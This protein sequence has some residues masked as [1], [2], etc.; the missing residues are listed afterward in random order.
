MNRKKNAIVLG[1]GGFIGH[2]L[3]NR[4]KSEGF[5]VL[6]ADL[7]MPDF[8]KSNADEFL[9][10]DLRNL[11]FV[12]QVIFEAVDEVYQL[13]GDVGGAGYIFTGLNDAN[14]MH[15]SAQINLNV[16][17][18][19]NERKVKSLFFAS[20]ACIY[21]ANNQSD[22]LN[23][24]CEESSAYPANPDSEYGWEKLMAER[25][26]LAYNRNFGLNVKI[27]RF[28][29]IYGPESTW[30]GGKEKAPAAIC[31]KVAEAVSDQKIQIWGTGQQTRS[32]LFIDDCIDATL[33]L[34]R[35]DFV[36]PYNVGSEEMISMLD[37]TKLVLKISDKQNP[38]ET[39]DGPIGVQGRCSHNEKISKDLNWIPTFSLE[40]GL[41]KLY[42]WILT[43]VYNMK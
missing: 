20:S 2:H 38:I 23:P 33:K 15:N 31:R 39:I 28:H 5:W 4:L 16:A 36:G 27:A 22:P 30:N 14:L 12:A 40:E 10:G 43:Q 11:D 24:N 13:A 17:K 26:Y 41:N 37:F 29:N 18:I 19:A 21:P 3:V 1:A 8:S 9:L 25:L 34:M 6:G 32:F 7:K 35:S 42:P